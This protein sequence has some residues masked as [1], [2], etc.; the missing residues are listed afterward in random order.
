M[1][2]YLRPL[3]V[4]AAG[5]L[6]FLLLTAALPAQAQPVRSAISP[7]IPVAEIEGFPFPKTLGSLT[8]QSKVD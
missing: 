7:D 5:F 3:I 6:A 1:P 8:R 2:R 4:R